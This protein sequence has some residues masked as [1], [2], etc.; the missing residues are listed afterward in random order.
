MT[1]AGV[2][3]PVFRSL[4][5]RLRGLKHL[6]TIF[7]YQDQSLTLL[8]VLQSFTLDFSK[9]YLQAKMQEN[10]F[11]F[12]DIAHFAIQILEEN[13]AIRQ[14]YIDKYHEVMVDE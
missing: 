13:D 2:K 14:L 11:E 9:Q 5:S 7:K 1:V 3:Y 8:Q 4:H 10:A 6:E 12:S